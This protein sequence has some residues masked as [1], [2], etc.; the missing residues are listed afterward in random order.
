MNKQ[1]YLLRVRSKYQEERRILG[2]LI[3]STSQSVDIFSSYK[4]HKELSLDKFNFSTKNISIKK[5]RSWVSL[6]WL[7]ACCTA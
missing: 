7:A 2:Y 5:V 1:I 4:L 3:S 6:V